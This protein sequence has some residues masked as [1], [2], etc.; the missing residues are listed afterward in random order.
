MTTSEHDFELLCEFAGLSNE[1]DVAAFFGIPVARLRYFLYMYPSRQYR[2]FTILKKSGKKRVINAPISFVKLLQRKLSYTLYQIYDPRQCVKGF[3]LDENIIK[4]AQ[5]HLRKRFI[6]NIDL[7]NFFDTIHFGRVRGLFLAEPFSFNETVA[8]LLAQLCCFNGKTPQGAPT[9]PIVSNMI[10]YKLDKQL[11]NFAR[12][13]NLVYTRY[14]DDITFSTRTTTFPAAVAF[15][16]DK[17]A[18]QLSDGLLR[19]FT[20]NG[21]EINNDKLKLSARHNRQEVTGLIVNRFVNVK[22][23]YVRNL[24]AMIHC[25]RIKGYEEASRL[26]YSKYDFKGRNMLDRPEAFKQVVQG[27]LRFLK[28]V[29]GADNKIYLDLLARAK[30][31]SPEDFQVPLNAIETLALNFNDLKR[32][33]YQGKKITLAER[34]IQLEKLLAELFK[35]FEV[36]VLNAFRRK[37]EQIDGAFKFDGKHF[38][39]ECK[40]KKRKSDHNDFASLSAKVRRSSRMTF[41]LFLSISGYTPEAIGLLKQDPDKIVIA[42]DGADLDG[43]L[44]QNYSLSEMLSFKVDSLAVKGEPYVP[45]KKASLL[46]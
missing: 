16:N 22:R 44:T 18:I 33:K 32:L 29:R 37:G 41:G 8:T 20:D 9:S 30:K 40:W 43:V 10:C 25:W 27:K 45:Y 46:A 26:F 3:V 11:M 39:F 24:R 14:A 34:G 5:T 12:A 6:L 2:T 38:L 7:S 15:E 23:N 1:S 28:D 17:G 19:I 4:N 36:P 35:I 42:M 31:A 13:N 21:F